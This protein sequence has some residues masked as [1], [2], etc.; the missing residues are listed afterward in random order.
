MSNFDLEGFGGALGLKPKGQPSNV[1]SPNEQRN[2]DDNALLVLQSELAKA[3]QGF[4]SAQT[5]EEKTRFDGDIVGLTREIKL[6]GG[7]VA[8]QPQFEA[9][10]QQETFDLEGFGK[11]LSGQAT[12]EQIKDQFAQKVEQQ[13]APKMRLEEQLGQALLGQK[14]YEGL[15]SFAMGAGKNISQGIATLQQLAGKGIG[16][17]APETGA[18]IAENA[19][20]AARSVGQKVAPY[21]QRNPVV[22]TAG[23]VTGAIFNP[24]NKL[25]PGFGGPAQSITGTIAKGAGQ[26]AIANVLTTPVTDENKAFLTEKLNQ[27]FVGG[28]A[29]GIAGSVLAGASNLAE[30]VKNQLG[31]VGNQAVETLRKAGVPVDVAQATGSQFLNRTK[32]ALQ[33]NPFTAGKEEAFA[34]TQKAAY[35]RAIARTM[36]EDAEA[37]TPDVIQ[38]AKTRLGR[39]YDELAS[40]NR[41]H[42]DNDLNKSLMDIE[43]RASTALTADQFS[44]VEKA[45]KNIK[46]KAEQTNGLIDGEQ[47]KNIKR[48]LSDI[49]RQNTPSSHY[50]GDLKDV[51][52]EGLGRSAQ[53]FGNQADVK[54][55]QQTNRQYSNMK[56]IEDVALKNVEG[57]VSPSLLSNSLATKSKR[58]AIYQDDPELANL[59]RAGKL[60][61]EQKLPNSGT[62]ARF[63]AQNPLLSATKAVY[64][65]GA[66]TVM[67]NPV[68]AAYLERGMKPGALRNFLEI[69]AKVG[70]AVP[71]Y[72]AKPGMAGATTL[73][74]LINMQNRQYEQENR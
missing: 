14:G 33:D 45:I 28:A 50:A 6:K 59:A 73:R 34:A 37:I 40:R 55:L 64:G 31:K 42:F 43:D 30:P 67:Q 38:A 32:A 4:A 53:K 70:E 16:M 20:Q 26:G 18:A 29:G 54:L 49:E 9:P 41:I 27:A 60:V 52:L 35:N 51:L 12:S 65:K 56:K 61:L 10:T 58:S 71:A 62:T 48:F 39:T 46:T 66:Q 44:V 15:Q 8:A 3:Q 69:P 68:T 1:V 23:E 36:G 24:V 7:K 72:A 57:D 74:E 19:A 25:V 47:Y 17:I 13:A 22:S 11:A 21:E 63:L 2:R 5:P